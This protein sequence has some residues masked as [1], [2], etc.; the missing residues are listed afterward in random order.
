M[1]GVAE[2]Q[3]RL[4]SSERWEL[5]PQSIAPRGAEYR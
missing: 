5:S 2:L 3:Q 1:A 4:V